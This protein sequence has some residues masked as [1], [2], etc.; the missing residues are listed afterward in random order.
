MPASGRASLK[1]KDSAINRQEKYK[2]YFQNSSGVG[3]DTGMSA[4]S[5]SCEKKKL[6][7]T[8]SQSNI[9]YTIASQKPE[10]VSAAPASYVELGKMKAKERK[11]NN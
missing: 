4:S 10:T 6:L 11:V 7:A 9:N 1:R 3:N 2:S 8:H 5:N